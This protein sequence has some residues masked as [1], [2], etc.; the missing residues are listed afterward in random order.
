M[1]KVK[2]ISNFNFSLPD[3]FIKVESGED[4][5][6][7]EINNKD[8]INSC[9][10]INKPLLIIADNPEL[11]YISQAEDFIIYPFNSN[12]LAIRL[13]VAILKSSSKLNHKRNLDP[14]TGIFHKEY[15]YLQ[16]QNAIKEKKNFSIL[17][18]DINSFKKINDSCG[19]LKGDEVLKQLAQI[20]INSTRASDVVS[21][22][23][24]DEFIIM[25]PDAKI[26]EAYIIG[27]RI[28]K[29]CEKICQ[30]SI[31]ASEGLDNLEKTLNKA[32]TDLYKNKATLL[33]TQHDFTN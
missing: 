4:I 16:C 21:R 6:L 5:V 26:N 8:S 2:V 24:G 14:L 10:S 7:L 25:L 32:D 27:E 29:N 3:G 30:I 22:F 12:E 13:K 17:I 9:N 11:I 20:I 33:T 28:R 19:H 18:L 15:F 31:G 23:G 1:I